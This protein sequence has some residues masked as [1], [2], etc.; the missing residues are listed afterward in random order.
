[1]NPSTETN[2]DR[3]ATLHKFLLAVGVIAMLAYTLTYLFAVSPILIR[4]LG[5]MFAGH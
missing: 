4:A 2:L 5:A 3:K 1:M